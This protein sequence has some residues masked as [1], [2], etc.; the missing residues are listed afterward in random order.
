MKVKRSSSGWQR[1]GLLRDTAKEMSDNVSIEISSR[2]E[3][4]DEGGNRWVRR[5]GDGG[6]EKLSAEEQMRERR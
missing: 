1:E 2:G 5:R 4:K 3:K 6:A